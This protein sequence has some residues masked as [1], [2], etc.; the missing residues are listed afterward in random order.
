MDE[1]DRHP[2]LEFAVIREFTRSKLPL[3]REEMDHAAQTSTREVFKAYTDGIEQ[4][5]QV[6]GKLAVDVKNRD[7]AFKTLAISVLLDM[8]EDMDK[9]RGGVFLRTQDGH[10]H[11][12]CPHGVCRAEEGA[13]PRRARRARAGHLLQPRTCAFPTAI[14]HSAP[15]HFVGNAQKMVLL[16][17][18]GLGTFGD[19]TVCEAQLILQMIVGGNLNP[20]TTIERVSAI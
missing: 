8:K 10:T 18:L 6:V 17:V 12:P 5:L 16:N 13:P 4:S 20:S 7:M 11:E 3:V 14:Q 1:M 2:L 15:P 9:E 19:T